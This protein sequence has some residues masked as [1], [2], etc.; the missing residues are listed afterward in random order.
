MRSCS[1]EVF[2]SFGYTKGPCL[3]R[4]SFSLF[5]LNDHRYSTS[6]QELG[7]PIP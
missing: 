6:V 3:F 4:D 1:L 7:I 5:V 2:L